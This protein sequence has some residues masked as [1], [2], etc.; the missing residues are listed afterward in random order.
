MAVAEFPQGEIITDTRGP[1]TE[2]CV[3]VIRRP[4]EQRIRLAKVVT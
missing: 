1:V 3:T 4:I 2:F